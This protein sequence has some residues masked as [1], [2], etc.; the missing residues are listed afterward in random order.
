[1]N[2]LLHSDRMPVIPQ[3][4]PVTDLFANLGQNWSVLSP[5]LSLLFGI[6]FGSF[7][8][9]KIVKHVRGSD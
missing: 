2:E 1:M 3:G 8:I 6:L 9:M 7:L 5:A 4:P